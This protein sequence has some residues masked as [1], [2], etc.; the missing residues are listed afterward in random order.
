MLAAH[1]AA[2]AASA[3][4]SMTW[5]KLDPRNLVYMELAEGMVVFELNHDFAPATVEQFKKLVVE[6]FYR[7]LSFY[8]VIDGFVAQAGDESDLDAPNAQAALKAEFEREFDDELSWTRVQKDALFAKET[9]F[10]DGFAAAREGDRVWLTHCPGVLAMARNNDPDS[11]ST[12]FYIVIGQ[13]PRYLDRNLTIFGHVIDGMEVVQKIN[14]GPTELNGIIEDDLER[15]RIKRLQLGK[16]LDENE[17]GIYY[18]MD[19][20]SKGFI[21]MMESRR[22]RK[23]DFFHHKP[24]KVLDVC[25]VPVRTRIEKSN[26]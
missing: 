10:I 8:R 20:N 16:D 12:D 14:R 26:R 1:L 13:A 19:T 23:D 4:E 5:R 2:P 25:Q 3:Q 6:D 7:S 22:N 9:G 11:G 21:E 17:E 18:R 15:T 24:P